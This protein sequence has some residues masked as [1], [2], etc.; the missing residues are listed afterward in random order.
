VLAL[1]SVLLVLP[2]P[3]ARASCLPLSTP[4]AQALDR[5]NDDEP[6]RAIREA[7]LRV[8]AAKP[9]LSDLARAE[10]Y[11]VIAHGGVQASRPGESRTAIE[12][13]MAL[14]GRLPPGPGRDRAR[15]RLQISAADI[16]GQTGA[17]DDAIR[18]LDG[19][20]V[21][22][23][24]NSR[25]RACALGVRLQAY[26]LL[27]Q[28]DRAAADG[29]TTYRIAEAGNWIEPR[30]DAATGSLPCTVAPACS[31]MRRR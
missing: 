7:T 29:I 18:M 8:A 17:F 26:A 27:N 28:T 31:A 3:G 12:A 20:L 9:P 24:A 16:S 10:L 13:G 23:P 4:E 14:I 6:D 21:D 19:L 22:M 1:A 30:I 25:E 5:Y 15:Q 11:A 2:S